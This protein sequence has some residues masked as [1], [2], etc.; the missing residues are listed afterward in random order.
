MV[1]SIGTCKDSDKKREVVFHVCGLLKSK[2]SK[3][4]KKQYFNHNDEKKCL[5]RMLSF[6]LKKVSELG[7]TI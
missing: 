7:G 3:V 4:L 5:A 6:D 2:L 1:K